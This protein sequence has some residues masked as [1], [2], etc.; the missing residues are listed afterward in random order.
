MAI[1]YADV[2]HD[3]QSDLRRLSA[4]PVGPGAVLWSGDGRTDGCVGNQRCGARE[5]LGRDPRANPADRRGTRGY[6]TT[7]YRADREP[8]SLLARADR[9]DCTPADFVQYDYAAPDGP[10]R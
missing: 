10:D 6:S 9:F 7:G 3:R 8:G 1:G 4:R 5:R 2:L